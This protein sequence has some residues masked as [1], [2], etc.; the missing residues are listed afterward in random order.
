MNN[1]D[2][3]YYSTLFLNTQF[4]LQSFFLKY[5]RFKLPNIVLNRT[6][7]YH[8]HLPIQSQTLCFRERTIIIGVTTLDK[9]WPIQWNWKE[10]YDLLLNSKINLIR[11][12]I[13]SNAILMKYYYVVNFPFVCSNLPASIV[14]LFHN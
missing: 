2:K 13:N 3:R 8:T 7:K 10:H 1:T 4:V 9:A 14:Y 6:S 12:S 5:I 11:A